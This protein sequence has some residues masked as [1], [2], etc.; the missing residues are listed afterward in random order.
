MARLLYSW[1]KVIGGLGFTKSVCFG[2]VAVA[3]W[4]SSAGQSVVVVSY[5]EVW[6]QARFGLEV[7]D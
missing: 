7:N 6:G 5:C 4:V 3:V 1:Y 2:G